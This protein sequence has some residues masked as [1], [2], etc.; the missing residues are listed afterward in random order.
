MATGQ[1]PEFDAL[2]LIGRKAPTPRKEERL[3]GLPGGSQDA[4]EITGTLCE[5]AYG[6]QWD[7]VG[8]RFPLSCCF[9]ALA[10]P[11][12]WAPLKRLVYRR[13]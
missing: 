12:P 2:D 11:R 8:S 13:K 5:K 7:G 9:C 4:T 3:S 1:G 6:I 10:D